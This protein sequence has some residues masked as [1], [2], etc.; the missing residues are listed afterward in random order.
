MANDNTATPSGS[1]SSSPVS[2]ASQTPAGAPPSMAGLAQYVEIT[3]VVRAVVAKIN[4]MAEATK[5]FKD[6]RWWTLL[7][8]QVDALAN[9]DM[10]YASNNTMNL[11]KEAI[12][13]RK[14]EMLYIVQNLSAFNVD[15]EEF[16]MQ[17]YDGPVTVRLNY[18]HGIDI[19]SQMAS[20]NGWNYLP[21]IGKIGDQPWTVVR[22]LMEINIWSRNVDSIAPMPGV[23]RENK[24]CQTGNRSGAGRVCGVSRSLWGYLIV[25]VT[26][27][28]VFT[29]GSRFMCP[30]GE[31]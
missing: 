12:R 30:C 26:I 25:Y 18:D 13:S 28:L 23:Q 15:P 8:I 6:L 29:A 20:H 17:C 21:S 1:R 5:F 2:I 24:Q 3:D 19:H 22:H 10:A 9:I 27:I 16:T 11:I 7:A 4:D 31:Q 14:E